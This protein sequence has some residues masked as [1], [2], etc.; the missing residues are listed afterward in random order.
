MVS[1]LMSVWG[2]RVVYLGPDT[3][4]EQVAVATTAAAAEKVVVSV[5]AATPR[6]R[7]ARD[8][9]SLR[10]ALPRG[11][12]VWVGGAGAPGPIRGVERFASLTELDERLRT[13]VA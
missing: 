6:A 9:A 13:L 10:K 8:I 12:P 3:P 11:V 5:S 7:A 1:V 4:I 2:Y